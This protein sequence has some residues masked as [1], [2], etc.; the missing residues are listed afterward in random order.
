MKL[1]VVVTPPSIY[2]GCSTWKT[3][4]EE[5]FTSKENLFLA[6][7]MKNCGRHNV[8]K[9]KEIKGSDKYTTLNISSKFDSMYKIKI[10][11][12]ESKGKLERSGKGLINSLG[13]KTKERS[14]KYK[15][16]R[17]VIGNFSKKD[18]SKIIKE[19]EKIEKVPYEKKRPKHEPTDSY[20][21][22]ARHLSKCMMR[23]DIL[24]WYDHGGYMKSTAPSSNVH[25]TDEEE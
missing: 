15:K 4:W 7:N 5:K 18:L 1:P 19:F 16:V 21:H 13:F 25:V 22:L 3:F 10:T 12:S 14:P 8:R 2:H 24:N 23:S 11:S 20:S 9:N 17:Y 6:V